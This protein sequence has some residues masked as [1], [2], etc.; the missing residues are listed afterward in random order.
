MKNHHDRIAE[1]VTD[2]TEQYPGLQSF[3]QCQG[4]GYV[5]LVLST[6][7]DM[8]LLT[9]QNQFSLFV[10]PC[11]WTKSVILILNLLN[12]QTI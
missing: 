8:E 5:T 1:Q 6:T 2:D 11:G 4:D 10:D 9:S 12:G 7:R 3:S